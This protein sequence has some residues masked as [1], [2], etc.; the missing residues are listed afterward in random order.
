MADVKRVVEQHVEAFNGRQPN[1]DPWSEDAEFIAPGATMHGRGEI[2]GFLGA[3]Q[4]AFPDARIEVS[5]LLG[6]GSVAAGEGRFMGTQTG[7]FRTPNGDVPPTGQRV[8]F[9]WMSSYEA[10]GDE[11]VSE[12]L[13]FDQTELLRQLGLM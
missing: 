7:T 5:R 8:E 2:L 3:F 12:H 13:F 9:R 1:A 11:L 4:E 10:R 6:E